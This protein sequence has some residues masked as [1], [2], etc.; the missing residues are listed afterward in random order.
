LFLFIALLKAERPALTCLAAKPPMEQFYSEK[1]LL[2]SLVDRLTE[3]HNG[4][5]P[6]AVVCN[7]EL[8]LEADAS[9]AQDALAHEFASA[10]DRLHAL[11]MSGK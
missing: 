7:L 8:T 4:Y 11:M 1:Q 2:A 6:A 5:G 3:G 10:L 9:L